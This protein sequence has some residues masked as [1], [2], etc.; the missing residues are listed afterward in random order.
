MKPVLN[1]HATALISPLVGYGSIRTMLWFGFLITKDMKFT[2]D[3]D[4]HVVM[5]IGI[6]CHTVM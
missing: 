6:S 2:T 3:T 4:I 1:A 5:N